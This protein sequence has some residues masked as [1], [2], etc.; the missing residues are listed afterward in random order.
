MVRWWFSLVIR[1][2]LAAVSA[3]AVF[4]FMVTA[5]DITQRLRKAAHVTQWAAVPGIRQAGDL[6]S[7]LTHNERVCFCALTFLRSIFSWLKCK[8]RKKQMGPAALSG[9]DYKGFART[10]S[11]IQ[12]PTKCTSWSSCWPSWLP[13]WPS[14]SP[15]PPPKATSRSS[16]RCSSMRSTSPT[17]VVLRL[18]ETRP[19]LCSSRSCLPSEEKKVTIFLYIVSTFFACQSCWK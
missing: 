14:P 4:Q 5:N 17:R 8:I 11:L 12:S 1:P 6:P 15:C 7:P 9:S 18:L 16:L 3:A 2:I 10:W 13:C 19:W